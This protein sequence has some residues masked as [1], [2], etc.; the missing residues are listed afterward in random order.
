MKKDKHLIGTDTT[1]KILSFLN[2]NNHDH[3]HGPAS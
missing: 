1:E 2:E 3:I